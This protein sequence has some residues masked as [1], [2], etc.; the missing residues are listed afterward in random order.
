MTEMHGASRGGSEARPEYAVTGGGNAPAAAP[1]AAAPALRIA[2]CLGAEGRTVEAALARLA[3]NE[4]LWI[5]LPEG[6]PARRD[7]YRRVGGRAHRLWGAGGY[8]LATLPRG[9]GVTRLAQSSLSARSSGSG[10]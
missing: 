9:V 7:A 5:E 8:S 6:E 10:E 1:S 4:A 3:P 2:N